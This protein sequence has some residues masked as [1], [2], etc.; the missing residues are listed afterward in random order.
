MKIWSTPCGL[1]ENIIL[2]INIS[3]KMYLINRHLSEKKKTEL[4]K[5]SLFTKAFEHSVTPAHTIHK[6]ESVDTQTHSPIYSTSNLLNLEAETGLQP[7][8]TCHCSSHVCPPEAD[9]FDQSAKWLDQLGTLERA[10]T[11]ACCSFKTCGTWPIRTASLGL[12]TQ[13]KTTP[14][15][16]R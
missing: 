7:L 13:P 16:Q 5:K 2:Y 3:W 4:S 9:Y 10:S 8:N 6:E 11:V 12:W 15:R 14:Q 1:D